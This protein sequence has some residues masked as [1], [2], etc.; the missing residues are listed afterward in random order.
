MAKFK[1]RSSFYVHL[2]EKV[3][4]PDTE[5]ELDDAQY[6]LVAHQVEPVEATKPS[7]KVKTDGAD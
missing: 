4:G 6:G 5:L 2:D 7:R 3:F 1:V